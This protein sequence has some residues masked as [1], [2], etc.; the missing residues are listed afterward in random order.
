MAEAQVFTADAAQEVIDSVVKSVPADEIDSTFK[1]DSIGTYWC[2][3]CSL[4]LA[5]L[6]Q[7]V[8]GNGD[9]TID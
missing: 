7:I 5:M 4:I 2:F 9:A 1:S 3:L 8:A 6:D